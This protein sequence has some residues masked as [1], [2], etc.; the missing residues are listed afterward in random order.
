VAQIIN[1][2]LK[3]MELL[4]GKKTIIGVGIT[5][6]GLLGATKYISVDEFT[7]LIDSVITIIGLTITVVGLIHKAIK[8]YKA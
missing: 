7:Q 5:L 8:A 4:N 3:N 6:I 1:L 2:I